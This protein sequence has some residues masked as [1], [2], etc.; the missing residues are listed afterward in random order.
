MTDWAKKKYNEYSEYY[1]PW[2]ED[3]YL[4]WFGE[5]KTS[6]TAKENIKSTKITGN[7]GVDK[8]QDGVADGV[9]GQFSQGGLLNVAGEGGFLGRSHR[10]SLAPEH[11]IRH[12]EDERQPT[13]TRQPTQYLTHI[14]HNG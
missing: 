9:G 2:I 11:P 3:K 4:A 10:K 1:M 6:Y 14:R 7:S 8:L 5:N 13:T 12:F